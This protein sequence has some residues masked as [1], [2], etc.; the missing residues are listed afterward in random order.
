M[1]CRHIALYYCIEIVNDEVMN[2]IDSIRIFG[3]FV[4]AEGNTGNAKKKAC[5]FMQQQKQTD[6]QKIFPEKTLPR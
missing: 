2:E 3:K 4:A 6:T 5:S 1:S